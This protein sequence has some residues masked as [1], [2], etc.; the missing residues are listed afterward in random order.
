VKEIFCHPLL[1]E[2]LAPLPYPPSSYAS[3]DRQT[4]TEI[5]PHVHHN[6]SIGPHWRW[7][8]KNV[9]CLTWAAWKTQQLLQ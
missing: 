3:T 5:I 1:W 6:A 9:Y 7:S 8:N 4:D 2:A